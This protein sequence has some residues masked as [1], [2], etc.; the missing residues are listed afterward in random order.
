MTTVDV[1]RPASSAFDSSRASAAVRGILAAQHAHHAT[2]QRRLARA[3]PTHRVAAI[4]TLI[5][6]GMVVAII[7][8]PDPLWWKLHFS[9]LGT[10]EAFSSYVFNATLIVAGVA[11]VAFA[12]YFRRELGAHLTR[13]GSRRR[14]PAVVSMLIGSIG[15]HLAFVG[16]IPV[17]TLTFLHDRAAT[18]L[19]FSF[20]ALLITTPAMLRGLGRALATITIPAAL[21]LVGGGT[22]MVMSIINLAAYELLGFA[23]MF[24][25][26]LMFV[27][28]LGRHAKMHDGQCAHAASAKRVPDAGIPAHEAEIP[29]RE[30]ARRRIRVTGAP[31]RPTTHL[32]RGV[33]R[34][35]SVPVSEPPMRRISD[36]AETYIIET[37]PRLASPR[38]MTRR[39][40][41][42]LTGPARRAQLRTP[43]PAV[44]ID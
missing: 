3:S 22:A 34:R 28:C 15:V 27:A 33:D 1:F 26:V 2:A 19:V 38:T 16:G 30:T 31:L 5:M 24:T 9:E 10:F 36:A 41:I 11:I 23:V 32:V 14:S 18:G 8:T 40:R 12:R 13:S 37:T 17:N 29:V 35:R 6:T 4:M 44:L 42:P 25:W 7:T 21:L 20:L 43:N 39:S